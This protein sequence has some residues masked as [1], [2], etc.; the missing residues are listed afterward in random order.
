MESKIFLRWKP[1]QAQEW[2]SISQSKRRTFKE[3]KGKKNRPIRGADIPGHYYLDIYDQSAKHREYKF[4]KLHTTY[5][6]IANVETERVAKQTCTHWH[7]KSWRSFHGFE[8]ARSERIPFLE[9]F[10]SFIENQRTV[11]RGA[12]RLLEKFALARTPIDKINYEWLLQFQ[13]YL[14]SAP[15]RAHGTLNR[16]SAATYYAKVKA[17]LNLAFKQELIPSN[18]SSRIK[19]IQQVPSQRVYLTR[20]EV[21]ALANTPCE[22]LEVKRAFL[23]S[24]YTGLRLSDVRALTWNR[25]RNGRL[26]VRI[27]KTGQPEYVDLSAVALKILGNRKNP[28]EPGFKLPRDGRLWIHLQAWGEAAGLS[29][30]LSF[31]VS[32]HTFATMMLDHT[33]DIYL[34]SKLLGH[35]D[36]KHTQVYAKI[37]DSRRKEAMLTLPSIEL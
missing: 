32:R 27:L 15:T 9:Y 36:I 31:H 37:M 13:E 2:K 20:E 3:S 7:D 21:Q 1:T 25:V 26:E 30:H 33:R 19:S 14:L 16:N 6:A 29:K 22:D 12:L 10:R 11:K 18:P 34:V 24:C 17:A 28:E 35:S 4:L 23:F 8:N 5:D